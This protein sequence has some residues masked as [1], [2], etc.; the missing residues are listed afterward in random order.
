[1]AAELFDVME[2]CNAVPGDERAWAAVPEFERDDFR[3]QADY[4]LELLA[5]RAPTSPTSRDTSRNGT[6][7]I[8]TKQF[9]K[10][11]I[12]RSYTA[13]A[14]LKALREACAL[15]VRERECHDFL[16]VEHG[17]Q[18]GHG[19]LTTV[20]DVIKRIQAALAEPAQLAESEGAKQPAKSEP[21]QAQT[22][23]DPLDPNT[24][25]FAQMDMLAD[26]AARKGREP[27][28]AA[29]RLRRSVDD[30]GEPRYHTGEPQ[31]G[32][33]LSGEEAKAYMLAR[34]GCQV[35]AESSELNA[36][37]L[38][39]SRDGAIWFKDGCLD[40][41]TSRSFRS[42]GKYGGE[43]YRVLSA[44]T[45]NPAPSAAVVTPT[46]DALNEA[47]RV[48]DN[49]ATDRGVQLDNLER[50]TLKLLARLDAHEKALRFL[51]NHAGDNIGRSIDGVLDSAKGG[52]LNG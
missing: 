2:R 20:L 40:W 4:V 24:D 34:P 38:Y 48:A 9:L 7:A 16:A 32:D 17:G 35:R 15:T 25:M 42:V 44:A 33:V 28:P 39:E 37:L 30:N 52:G 18:K 29:V 47:A 27:Q 10:Q 22:A 45:P 21:A 19:E 41:A 31:P 5:K 36:E 13:E 26:K 3:A 46:L 12:D 1:M 8:V 49:R 6:Y 43:R 23:H 50:G 51:A 11:M 14:Q